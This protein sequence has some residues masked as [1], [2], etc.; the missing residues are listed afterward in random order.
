MHARS[1]VILVIVLL[2]AHGPLILNDGLIMDDWMVLKPN[3]DYAIDIDF[4]LHGA[5]HPIFFTYFSLANATSSPIL[6]MKVAALVAVLCGS[7]CLLLGA[8]RSNLLTS[9][10]AVGFALIVW[11]YP[12]YQ[13]WAGKANT[14]YLFSFGL[15]FVGTWLLTLCWGAK[16][17]A[18]AAL[19]VLVVFVFFFSFALNSMMVL[20]AFAMLGLFVAVWRTDYQERNSINFMILWRFV[21]RYPELVLLPLVYWG[22]FNIWFARVGVYKEHYNSHLPTFREL[23]VGWSAFFTSG[24]KDVLKQTLEAAVTGPALFVPATLLIVIGLLLV[25]RDNAAFQKSERSIVLPLV[26]CPALFLALSLPYLIAGL[27]PGQNLYETRH[28]LLFGVPLALGLL[29]VKRSVQAAVGAREACALILGPASIASVVMLWNGYILLQART[30]KQS[31]LLSHLATISKPDALVFA[32]DDRLIGYPCCYEPIGIPEATGMLRLAWGNWPFLGFSLRTE[33]PTV[34]QEMEILR[35][36][37][38][39]AYSHID[40]SGP[41]ATISLQPG[42]EAASDAS[43]VRHYFA[44]RLLLRCD[45]STLLMRLARVTINIGP[46]AGVIPV[47]HSK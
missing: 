39:S 47:Q 7:V 38:G 19:R 6:F 18:H 13:L 2:V 30:L 33:R 11:T 41:Q 3:R 22:I 32:I 23:I 14:A 25:P 21:Q 26:L 34:L 42:S 36:G 16:G 43:L 28:L 44:C 40:P 5:G 17:A 37:E 20:Y 15:L 29:A 46:I 35:T 10:E 12:G 31:A 4:L 27:R 24:Y 8:L 9:A 1:I 45:I